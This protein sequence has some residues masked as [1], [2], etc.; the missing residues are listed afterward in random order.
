MTKGRRLREKKYP[1][2]FTLRATHNEHD[3][4]LSRAREAKLSLSRFLIECGL[5]NEAPTW[6]DRQQRERTIIQLIRAGNNL[7][8]IAGQLNSQRGTINYSNLEQ[9]LKTLKAVLQ[10]IEGIMPSAV[11]KGAAGRRFQA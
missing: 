9:T 6:E 2:A 10:D 1:K 5:C 8:Q 4:L 3:R 7:N 11:T